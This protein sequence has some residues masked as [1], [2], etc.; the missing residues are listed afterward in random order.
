MSYRAATPEEAVGDALARIAS[1]NPRVNAVVETFDERAVEAARSAPQ[2][3]L[4]G[5]PVV[6]K[7]TFSLP[8]RAPLEGAGRAPGV[9]GPG[10]AAVYELLTRA[11]AIVVGVAHM[12]QLGIG[13][14]GAIA[15]DGPCR[16]PWDLDRVAGGSSSGSAVAV[17]ASMVPVAIGTDGAGSIRIPAANCGV[18]GLKPTYGAVSRGGY[19]G[20]YSTMAAIGPMARDAANCRSVAEVLMDRTLAPPNGQLRV[21]VVAGELW[22]DVDPAVAALC[23]DA[24]EALRSAGAAV[25]TVRIDHMEHVLLSSVTRMTVERLPLITPA[26]MRQM[27]IGLDPTIRG[28]LMARQLVT[29]NLLVRIDRVRAA[30]RR[31]MKRVFGEVDLLA[32][33]TCPAV[34]ASI[35][36]PVVELPSGRRLAE[37]AATRQCGL[38]NLT[39]IPSISVPVGLAHGLPVGLVLHA[40]WDRE[41]LLFD[42]SER[43]ERVTA[44]AHVSLRPSVCAQGSKS[45]A[46]R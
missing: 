38:A 27:S 25:T 19:S 35:D 41:D 20:T 7:D 43:I 4:R 3:P 21:G 9:V 5:L 36:R 30:L 33:P 15:A 45:A 16:N 37:L 17:A 11:G 24:V 44:R 31:E 39:G 28:I 18:V 22:E 42:A 1:V 29:G 6:I 40:A 12:H 2:G 14:T 34:A 46:E 8:W 23:R 13:G 10:S 26:W 32:W